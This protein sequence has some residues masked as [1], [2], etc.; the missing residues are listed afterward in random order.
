MSEQEAQL[1]YTHIGWIGLCPVYIGDLDK[2][3]PCV[4]VR[5]PWLEY[6]LDFNDWLIGFAIWCYSAMNPDW[7]PMFPIRITGKIKRGAD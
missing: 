5:Y 2:E 3:G 7:E 6:W 4:K 1:E